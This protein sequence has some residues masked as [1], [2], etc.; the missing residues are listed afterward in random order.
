MIIVRLMGGLGNQLFQYAAGRRL[1]HVRTTPL[2]L[3]L[4]WFDTQELRFYELSC[5]QLEA[6]CATAAEVQALRD[7]RPGILHRLFHRTPK[8]PPS[9]VREQNFRFDARVLDL[10]ADAFLDGYW[11][12]EKYFLDIE[13]IL[14][15]DFRFGKPANE[16]NR[17]LADRIV[18]CASVSLHVRRTDYVTNPQAKARHGTCTP[19][20]YANSVA[21]IAQMVAAPHFF[22][23]SDDPAWAREK[24]DL[25]QPTTVVDLNG[26]DSGYEDLRLMTRCRHHIIANSSF[27]WWG[28]WLSE[29]PA[30]IVI[31]PAQ[32]FQDGSRDT[33]DLLPPTWTR[34]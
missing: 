1:S 4:S 5:F 30:K 32:W 7:E 33:M 14:R 25:H 8:P 27:S 10:G 16:L 20:Y 12:S 13:P 34:L 2:K 28:A 6:Q 23:F 9:W 19:E 24:L 26:P 21:R 11:Q 3:D 31:A 29:S 17:A 15:E 22:V 18:S